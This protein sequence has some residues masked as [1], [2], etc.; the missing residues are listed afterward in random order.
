MNYQKLLER[1]WDLDR[2]FS[3]KETILYFYLLHRCNSLGWPETFSL[4]NDELI[5]RLKCRPHTM[6]EAR[7]ALIDS[8]LITYQSGNGRRNNS[9]YSIVA[10]KTKKGAISDY[11]FEEKGCNLGLPFP[12]KGCNLGLPFSDTTASKSSEANS[13][14]FNKKG[15]ISDYLFE[16]LKETTKEKKTIPPAPPIKEKKEKKKETRSLSPAHTPTPVCEDGQFTLF[17]NDA[18]PL[19]KKRN[20]V[21]PHLPKDME[22]VISFFEKNAADKLPEWKAEAELFFYHFDS[23]GWMGT[24]NRKIQD[25]ESRAN[26]WISDKVLALKNGEQERRAEIDARNLRSYGRSAEM[27]QRGEDKRGERA[28]GRG[29]E[30]G[31]QIAAE[32]D[33]AKA[34]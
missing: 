22:E 20:P 9:F 8:G 10:E 24:S 25:W 30:N 27:S 28:Y 4:S 11:L 2:D 7:K 14:K 13:D 15:A 12:E 34:W 33:Y 23:V 29:F 31:E 1:F 16:D 26:L 5:E 18:P 17:P 6:M 19:K 32:K 21:E 3:D